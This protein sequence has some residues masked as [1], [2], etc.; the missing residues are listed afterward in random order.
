M[1]LRIQRCADFWPTV[2]V[3]AAKA[4]R[5]GIPD[6]TNRAYPRRLS[7]RPKTYVPCGLQL[8]GWSR[9][10]RAQGRLHLTSVPFVPVGEGEWL[11]RIEGTS[12]IQ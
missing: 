11:Q 6:C 12:L 4:V 10:V 8:D 5:L 2:C 7:G 1:R 3:A 9:S